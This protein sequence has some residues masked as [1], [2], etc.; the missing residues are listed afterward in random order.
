MAVRQTELR[1]LGKS[2]GRKEDP[3]FIRGKGRYLDD[4]SLPGMLYMCLVRSPYA[5]ARIKSIDTSAALQA[6]GVKLVITGEDLAAMNLAWMPTMAN[7]QQMVLA[8]GKVLFQYQE[9]AAVIAETREQAEDAAQLVYVEYEPLPV[10]VDPFKAL[11][12]DAPIL[13]EDREQKSNLI[14]HWEA[15][16]K[17]ATE[18]L[19]R[20]AP[21]V[22]KQDVRF[23]RVHP[24]PLEP[25]GCIA[26]YNSATGKLTW[27]VTS[28]APH[29]H[30]TV[31]SLVSGLPEH[32]IRVISPD[33]GGGF[34]NK[35]PVYPGYVCAIVASLKLGKP[36]KWIETRTENTT[37]TG[38]ARD[39]HMTAEIAAEEDGRVLAL[40]VKTI[41]DHGAF[42][43]AADPSK[44]PAGLF[45]IVTG[46]YD[47]KEAFVEV[48][49]VYTNK[50]PGGVAY[51]CSFRVTEAAYLIE[52]V[53]DVL[54]RRV[55]VDP[56]E[57]RRRNFI[58][59]EQFPYKS[60]TGWTYDS[61]DY[62]KTLAL[63]LE[64][65][66][67]EQLRKEQAEKR[68]RGELMGIGISTF[69]EVVGAGPS[70]TFDIM[71][72]K[73]FDSAQ[74]RVHPTGKVIAR[75]GV[76]H[77]GQ[78][79]E[80]TFAQIIAEELGLSTDDVIVEEGDT[81]TAPY[82]L[83]TYA[84]RSTPTAGG[85][86]ALCARRIRE[87]AKKIAAHLL[88]VGEDDVVFDGVGF[89]AKGLASRTV[90][91][92]DIAFA[93]YTNVPEGMEP[94]LEA[95]Y[96]Y[97]PPNLTFPH[98]AYIAV[99]DIDKGTGAVKVRRFLAVDDCGTVINPM[100]VEGQVHGGLTEGFAI[101]FMQD[102]P[103]DEDGNC[104]AT[105]W[106]DYLV[107]TALDTPKWETDRT[108]TPSPHH[109]IG[110]KGVGESPNVGSPAAFVNAVVD[111]LAPLGVEHIDMPIYPW[112][113]WKILREHGVTE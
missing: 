9:V 13:R 20:N 35:V 19:F 69:T 52:R 48:D 90:T 104:L 10:V 43:A 80:T 67:Y 113:V 24:S 53:M 42:D 29:A 86:A 65:I 7:D 40:R 44:F 51:R 25:C 49:G 45:S 30:R 11:E 36:V 5:H 2:V 99:V 12:S 50:A 73:M 34:G 91:M 92:K 72:I 6:P 18:E 108:V 58:R 59:K 61:G 88:E 101:A 39:Y 14:F 46:S 54:A 16:D 70:H 55:G 109:P 41:A 68:A 75:L 83:G 84:S 64:K 87:K 96:Y 94:G 71:G 79:H 21:V 32:Q 1:P 74:I 81:D 15:G 63:A 8:T 23:P 26:D 76:R 107:P 89:S 97:D 66:G 4:I 62:E 77:Q 3:R 28:Q 103:F 60:P 105:N 106:M 57:L 98:G 37:S 100:I 33:V 31:L 102:I 47:F 111:A 93:A 22:V 112:K 56:A 110:A 85:A 78:G 17:E 27:Y 82:G 38:F 95:T